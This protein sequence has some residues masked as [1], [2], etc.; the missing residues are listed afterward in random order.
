MSWPVSAAPVAVSLPWMNQAPTAP[1]WFAQA[2]PTASLAPAFTFPTM[3][4]TTAPSF[5]SFTPL[6]AM[7]PSAAAT[8]PAFPSFAPS[9]A[10]MT[11][12]A[13]VVP[14][15]PLKPARRGVCKRDRDLAAS[16]A[17]DDDEA[18]AGGSGGAGGSPVEKMLRKMSVEVDEGTAAG[19]GSVGIGGAGH[20]FHLP[21]HSGALPWVASGYTFPA[22]FAPAAAVPSPSMYSYQQQQQQ[23]Y[24]Q[25]QQQQQQQQYQQQQQQYHNHAAMCGPGT[26]DT[27]EPSPSP[28]DSPMASPVVTQ[29]DLAA[30]IASRPP[31]LRVGSYHRHLLV[32]QDKPRR[33]FAADGGFEDYDDDDDAFADARPW[34]TTVAAG[35]A[36]PLRSTLASTGLPQ[37]LLSAEQA[38]RL[39]LIPFRKQ[40]RLARVCVCVCLC[41]SVCVC[42]FV[43]AHVR[44]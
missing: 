39:A 12:G 5:P 24:Q 29:P 16:A 4:P 26:F 10:S 21:A 43:C 7:A 2:A 37:Q 28:T 19:G 27:A 13:G 3:T 17:A 35:V 18:G 23:Q 22:S 33:V 36:A 38:K 8:L 25:Q 15:P 20:P 42:V 11:G 31:G 41:V 40:V 6:A 30:R 44:V 34:S 14:P 32:E 9:F 1:S